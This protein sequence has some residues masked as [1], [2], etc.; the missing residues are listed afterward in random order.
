MC[1][2]SATRGDH[3]DILSVDQRNDRMR[4]GVN[5]K[6]LSFGV[7]AY[8]INFCLVAIN[9]LLVVGHS[10]VPCQASSMILLSGFCL[11]IA[12]LLLV[13]FVPKNAPHRII[14]LAL[15]MVAVFAHFV[16]AH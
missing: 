14:P 4:N 13:N 8:T 1:I 9:L 11:F 12:T 2:N 6:F 16:K 7:S 5:Q 10:N 3:V 15:G